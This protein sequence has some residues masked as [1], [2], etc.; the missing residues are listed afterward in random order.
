[1]TR[2]S[3]HVVFGFLVGLMILCAG[4]TTFE[5]PRG[6]DAASARLRLREDGAYVKDGLVFT[7]GDLPS[8]VT[9]NP[10]VHAD[11]VIYERHAMEM[12]ALCGGMLGFTM[13]G[14]AFLIP[15][16]V[17]R[18]EGAQAAGVIQVNLGATLGLL[19]WIM[20]RVTPEE[21]HR[22]IDDYNH[23]APRPKR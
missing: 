4:C 22:V 12:R 19:Y 15:G 3:A 5:W 20:S 17:Y 23:H 2:S 7:D 8:L 10:R 21:R 14:L 18:V 13:G 16:V 9:D 6:P 1:M 11:A